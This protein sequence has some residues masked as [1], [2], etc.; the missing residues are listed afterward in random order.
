MGEK[1]EGWVKKSQ[2]MGDVI[3]GWPPWV[4]GGSEG[5]TS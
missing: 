1:G 2:I 5:G 3:Y 4:I